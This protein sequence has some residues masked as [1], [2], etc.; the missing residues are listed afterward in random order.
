MHR[1]QRGSPLPMPPSSRR[2]LQTLLP[3]RTDDLLPLRGP[4]CFPFFSHVKSVMGPCWT[5]L[6]PWGLVSSRFGKIP[7][8]TY[9]RRSRDEICEIQDNSKTLIL[10]IGPTTIGRCWL[11]QLCRPGACEGQREMGNGQAG[12]L[13]P[14]DVLSFPRLPVPR[15]LKPSRTRAPSQEPR[16]QAPAYGSAYHHDTLGHARFRPDDKQDTWQERVL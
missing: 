5:P 12:W 4:T 6:K 2:P 10:A 11:R 16:W 14:G 8:N 13:Q 9:L 7:I 3:L 15:I 1:K